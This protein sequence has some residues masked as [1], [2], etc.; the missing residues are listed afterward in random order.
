[1]PLP[2]ISVVT[3]CLN[4]AR[5]IRSTVES[6][7]AQD[8]P[9]AEYRVADGG[10]TDGT[11]DILRSYGN[12]ILLL[13]GP[14]GG[15]ADAI[16]GGLRRSTGD[17]VTWINA[18]DAYLPGA[19]AAVARY[20]EAHEEAGL[21]FGRARV[22][23]EDGRPLGDYETAS[24][25]LMLALNSE[26]DGHRR[27]LLTERSGWIP[28]QTAF[29]RRRLM[30]QAGFLDPS[31]HYAMDYEYWLRLGA[32]APIHFL[33]AHLGVFRLHHDAKSTSAWRQWREVLM[34]NR[35]YHGPPGSPIHR[36]FLRACAGAL[37]RRLRGAVRA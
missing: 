3:P 24:A 1:M 21:V 23:A 12:R 2:S 15:Q 27:M 28:Q 26:P 32:V 13:T 8:P 14:D 35:R 6:V 33:D 4:A 29:W 37:T 9:P 34:I 11:L 10:S 19:F 30:D 25:G 7:L 31:L 17:I 16:N 18:S 20:F 22:V 36:A 5:F